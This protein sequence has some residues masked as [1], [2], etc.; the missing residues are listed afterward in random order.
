MR[1][2]LSLCALAG[3]FLVT[4][5]W[6]PLSAVRAAPTCFS[7]VSLL[8]DSDLPVSP[9][10]VTRADLYEATEAQG[11]GYLEG[12]N[13]AHGALNDGQTFS[14]LDHLEGAV[15]PHC[16]WAQPWAGGAVKVLVLSYTPA[17]PEIVDLEQRLNGKVYVGLLPLSTAGGFVAAGDHGGGV[18]PGGSD[19]HRRQRLVLGAGGV[20]PGRPDPGQVTGRAGPSVPGPPP[21]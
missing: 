13:L 17:A 11:L 4:A 5:A 12:D 2:I 19:D 16:T 14:V 21:C 6:G 3:I 10:P 9:M 8:P 18:G 1:V 7:D 15:L 20:R